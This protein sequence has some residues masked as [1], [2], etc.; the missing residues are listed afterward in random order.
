M[1]AGV[2]A[3][4][5]ALHQLERVSLTHAGE[6]AE[7]GRDGAGFDHAPQIHAFQ[8]SITYANVSASPSVS[9]QSMQAIANV[10][11]FGRWIVIEANATVPWT[12]RNAAG[13]FPIW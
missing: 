4:E 3:R 8:F 9:S 13:C 5:R 11:D 2:A 10:G 1:A 7:L 6:A 12:M